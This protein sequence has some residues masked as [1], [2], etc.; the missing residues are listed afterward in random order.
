MGDLHQTIGLGGKA[1]AALVFDAGPG[2]LTLQPGDITRVEGGGVSFFTVTPGPG[3]PPD[4]PAFALTRG[5][6]P[7]ELDA[8]FHLVGV[9]VVNGTVQDICAMLR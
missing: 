6:T 3:V 1:G 8:L 4:F 5:R 2:K 7:A 9:S